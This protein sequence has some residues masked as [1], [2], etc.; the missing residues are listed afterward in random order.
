M[1]FLKEASVLQ[2]AFFGPYIVAHWSVYT[3]R[4]AVFSHRKNSQYITKTGISQ[5]VYV[6]I[7]MRSGSGRGW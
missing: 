1:I 7:G 3:V 6:V 5:M 4:A 2:N